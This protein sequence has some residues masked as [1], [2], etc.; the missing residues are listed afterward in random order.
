MPV[1]SMKIDQERY[2]ALSLVA[3][4]SNTTKNALLIEAV[5]AILA[6]GINK[7]LEAKIQGCLSHILGF[8]D[9]TGFNE[10]VEEKFGS[11]LVDLIDAR[12]KV[13]FGV[14]MDQELQEGS[15][16]ALMQPQAIRPKPG[17]DVIK[18]LG[19]LEDRLQAAEISLDELAICLDVDKQNLSTALSKV[20]VKTERKRV[21]GER[22]RFY[23]QD[24]LGA[25][26]NALEELRK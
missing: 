25:V 13:V 10:A 9:K 6:G 14:P 5:D 26:K 23:M 19:F 4:Q 18:A 22:Q 20:G 11:M 3:E 8:N 16:A 12:M 7:V 2:D 17:I 21:G 24:K 15:L 1:F